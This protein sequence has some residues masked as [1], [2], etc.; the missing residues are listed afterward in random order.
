MSQYFI[1][2]F[3]QGFIQPFPPSSVPPVGKEEGS[4]DGPWSDG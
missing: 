2:F 3:D 1:S 4:R